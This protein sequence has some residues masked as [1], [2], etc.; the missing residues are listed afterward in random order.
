MFNAQDHLRDMEE[1]LMAEIIRNR[2]ECAAGTKEL[3]DDLESYAA[4]FV[5]HEQR[6]IAIEKT[7]STAKK[8]SYATGAAL[9][10]LVVDFLR[11]HM[12]GI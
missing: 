12:L 6:I 4:S 3:R 11:K 8:L 9:S 1:R 7:A 2:T 5:V 10:G